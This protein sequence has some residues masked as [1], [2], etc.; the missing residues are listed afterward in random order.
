MEWFFNMTT[1]DRTHCKHDEWNNGGEWLIVWLFV[2]KMN[3]LEELKNRTNLCTNPI[4]W[5]LCYAFK[6]WYF[7]L[8]VYM[9][10]K[11]GLSRLLKK[12]IKCY[13][14]RLDPRKMR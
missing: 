1:P 6:Y 9:G 10:V 5:E 2:W 14:K 11:F 4:L 7:F 3:Y 13:E 12:T 8:F